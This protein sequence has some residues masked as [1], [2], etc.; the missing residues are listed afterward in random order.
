MIRLVPDH[1]GLI[2]RAPLVKFHFDGRVVA[3]HAGETVLAAL[4]RAGIKHLRDAPADGAPRGAFCCMGLCQECLV[5][6]DGVSVES[7]RQTVFEGLNVQSLR[8]HLDG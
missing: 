7:C 8:R 4:L 6:V 5:Q 3:G 1:S 2:K